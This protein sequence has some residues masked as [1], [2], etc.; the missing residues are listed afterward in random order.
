VITR[1]AF[2]FSVGF[3]SCEFA[4]ALGE[5]VP[6]YRGARSQAMGGA[7]TAVADDEQAIFLNPAG[8][9]GVRQP[10]VHYGV[11]DLDLSADLYS[12]VQTA[13]A[14]VDD[15]SADLL[16][17]LM[18]QNIYGRGQATP[19]LVMPNFGV[20]WISDV[21]TALYLNNR[22]L[23]Q[24][25]LGYQR[26]HGIQVAAAY[27]NTSQYR[28]R[29]AYGRGSLRFGLGAKL[30]W[31]KGGYY[32]MPT[33]TFFQLQEGMAL[34]DKTFGVVERGIG[35]DAGM[36]YVHPVN[37]RL[38]LSSGLAFTDI[39]DTVFGGK[40]SPQL[41]N[42][43]AGVAAKYQY[44]YMGFLLAFDYHHILREI[45]WRKKNHLGLEVALPMLRV[46]GGVNQSF[47]TYGAA[48]KAWLFD[49]HLI[50]YAEELG[51]F[52]RQD[53]NRRYMLRLDLKFMI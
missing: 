45:D 14:G 13:L 4:F 6:L 9:A 10:S 37:T 32:D 38:R 24:M 30:L 50:S 3:L 1:I 23:P 21:Q 34:L 8:L 12:T 17:T 28:G 16:N 7:Y 20:A 11:G 52:A 33:M 48:F 40:A 47:L 51:A 15:L 5:L 18:G 19:S 25:Q 22:A 44:R 26:T 29:R 2:I 27:S 39:G 36:Q 53:P 31:R 41:G 49:V 42:L 35:F 43:K 46:Y